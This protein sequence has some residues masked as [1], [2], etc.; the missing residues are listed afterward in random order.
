MK[1]GGSPKSFTCGI[2]DWLQPKDY[3]FVNFDEYFKL[4]LK[5]F[6]IRKYLRSFIIPLLFKL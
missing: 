5:C 4:F 2:T 6:S 1:K 3:N